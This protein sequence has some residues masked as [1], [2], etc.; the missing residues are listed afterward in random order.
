MYATHTRVDHAATFL[1][2]AAVS[3]PSLF[4]TQPWL[5]TGGESGLDLY[6]D[7]TRRLPLA[8]PSGREL[9]ISCGAALFNVRLAMRH[10]GFMPVVRDFPDP[11]NLAHLAHVGWGSYIPPSSDEELM[12]GAVRQ[13]RTHRGPFQA[14]RLPQQLVDE[15]RE[16][17]RA[18]GA[19]LYTVESRHERSRLSDLVR[20][21]ERVCRADPGHVAEL[22][23][24]TRASHSGRAD[25]V[26]LS[27]SA[28]HPD[29]TALPDRDFLGITRTM[30]SPPTVWPARTGL[31][32]VITTQN[33]SRQDWLRAGQA[34]QRVLLYATAHQVS[35]AF[36]TQPLEL[37]RLRTEVRATIASG[38]FPQ[39]ILRLGNA[40]RALPTP[41]RSATS[42]LSA[43]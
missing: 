20:T 27:V 23:S 6:A 32:A 10:L 28:Y 36:H 14:S 33:D 3:A 42:V 1:V 35:A 8:D 21:A 37:P 2:R 30:P 26:P 41:R 29:S 39:M 15:L 31:I 17:A 11:W 5:F 13:R 40:P 16:H 24:W 19:E 22:T 12:Y 18:E 43:G 25:G 9:V 34:L 4:N 38:E 7:P